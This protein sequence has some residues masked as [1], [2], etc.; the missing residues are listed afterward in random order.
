MEILRKALVTRTID[1][2]VVCY[3][4]VDEKMR[5]L[6]YCS[7]SCFGRCDGVFMNANVS[8]IKERF[9]IILLLKWGLRFRKD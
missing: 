2:S 4:D 6:D 9:M 5:Y 3:F 8:L 1:L 7:V